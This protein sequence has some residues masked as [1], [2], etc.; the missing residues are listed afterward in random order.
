MDRNIG[1]MAIDLYKKIV[2]E[3]STFPWCHLR[4]GGLGEPSLHPN[5]QEML[6]YLKGRRF[7]VEIIT[8][9]T[10]LSKF[11]PRRI[12][13]WGID[14]LGISIDGYDEASYKQHR[15]G[16]DYLDLR[17]RIIDLSLEKKATGII[18]PEIRVRNVIFPDYTPEKIRIFK[19]DW[20]P[21]VDYI[22]FNTLN[23]GNIPENVSPILCTEINSV[24]YIRWDGTVPL[25][26]YQHWSTKE[27][28]L[29]NLRESSLKS[30]WLSDGLQYLRRAHLSNNFKGLDYCKR[31][32]HTQRAYFSH[33][34]AIKWNQH[35]SSLISYVR[36]KLKS[37]EQ[38]KY[39]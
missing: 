22:Q 20:L 14:I 33:E 35:K 31:C 10:L 6:D 12:L 5:I 13:D 29:G 21:F 17:Q 4:I 36:R 11:T 25:C 27:E 30:L 8:N 1:Y 28:S 37:V 2:N 23:P 7:K 38:R 24:I 32:Y 3:M 39:T 9:G 18:Y 16:G 34:N 26:G 15:P 19:T